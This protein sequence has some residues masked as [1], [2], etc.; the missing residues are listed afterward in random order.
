MDVSGRFGVL[1]VVR[2]IGV[3]NALIIAKTGTIALGVSD[4]NDTA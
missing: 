3:I 4:L 2:A 1:D